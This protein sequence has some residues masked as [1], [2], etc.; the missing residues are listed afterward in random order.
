M[1]LAG[2]GAD[3]QPTYPVAGKVVFEDGTPLAGGVVEFQSVPQD[4]KPINAS[5]AIQP[6]GTFRLGTYAAD[7]GAVAGAHKALVRPPEVLADIEEGAK[8]PEPVLDPKFQSYE[9]SGLQFTVAQGDNHF[10][11]RVQR[12]AGK[13]ADR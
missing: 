4:G 5:G 9:T 11:L 13:A 1:T 12:P 2:C 3:R 10:T 7:D 6:D 8:P